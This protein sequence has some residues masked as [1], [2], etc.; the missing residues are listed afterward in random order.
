MRRLLLS[1]LLL[2]F[3]APVHTQSDP[4]NPDV[5]PSCGLPK[6]GVIVASVTYNL[7]GN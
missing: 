4:T 7:T 2:L 5:D 1:L 6:E 3:A